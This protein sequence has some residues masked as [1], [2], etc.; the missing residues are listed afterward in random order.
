MA[1][2]IFNILWWVSP[3]MLL[4]TLIIDYK[5]I[6]GYVKWVF[7]K[8]RTNIIFG[9]GMILL[10][11]IAFPIVSAFLLGKAVFKQKVKKAKEEYDVRTKGE[12]AEFEELDSEPIERI[13]LPPS[14]KA[15]KRKMPNEYDDMFE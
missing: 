9:L 6:T 3:L 2:F 4:A 5:V 1:R 8:L 7:S 15:E 14:P 12:F 10:T 13:E 11:V